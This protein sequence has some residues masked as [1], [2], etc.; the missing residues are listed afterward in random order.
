MEAPFSEFLL[1]AVD[2]GER[3]SG[4]VLFLPRPRAAASTRGV[5]GRARGDLRPGEWRDRRSSGPPPRRSAERIWARRPASPRSEAARGTPPPPPAG[6]GS[7][8]PA[9]PFRKQS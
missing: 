9:L 5:S 6:G 1:D 4:P 3:L 8:R 7:V 2:G